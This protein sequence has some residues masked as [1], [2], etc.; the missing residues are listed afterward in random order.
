MRRQKCSGC[1]VARR[2]VGGSM[3]GGGRLPKC[4]GGRRAWGQKRFISAMKRC[5]GADK[6]SSEGFGTGI[7]YSFKL[8]SVP[9]SAA[10]PQ[11]FCCLNNCVAC[12]PVCAAV[13]A[14]CP[15][16]GLCHPSSVVLFFCCWGTGTCSRLSVCG[17]SV[18]GGVG[19]R[20]F[21][22]GVGGRRWLQGRG[23]EYV[24]A[25]SGLCGVWWRGVGSMVEEQGRCVRRTFGCSAQGQNSG[26]L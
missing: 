24:C 7:W 9:V 20:K 11:Q 13:C 2:F 22:G 4:A 8:L 3:G 17:P 19:G 6:R 12:A 23:R 14:S 18:T 10:V 16:W 21:G 25:S 26:T 15:S 5:G 1:A